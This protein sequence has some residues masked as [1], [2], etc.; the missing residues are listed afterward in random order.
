MHSR[1]ARHQAVLCSTCNL[2][3][4]TLKPIIDGWDGMAHGSKKSVMQT[5]ELARLELFI[6]RLVESEVIYLC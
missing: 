2:S 5:L 6:W 3:L 1:K 4:M